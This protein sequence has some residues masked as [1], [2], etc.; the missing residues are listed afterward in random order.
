MGMAPVALP[1]PRDLGCVWVCLL[2]ATAAATPV[3]PGRQAVASTVE[4]PVVG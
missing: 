4:T 1:A 3:L 2:E